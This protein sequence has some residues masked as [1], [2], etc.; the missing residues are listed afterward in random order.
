VPKAKKGIK[1]SFVSRLTL[2]SRRTYQK[3]TT[4]IAPSAMLKVNCVRPVP[5][6]ATMGIRST[7][8]IG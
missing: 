1:S 6:T 8:G 2:R 5:Q 7:P 4:F 3:R